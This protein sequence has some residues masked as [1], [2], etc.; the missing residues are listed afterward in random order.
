MARSTCWAPGLGALLVSALMAGCGGGGDSGSNSGGSVSGNGGASAAGAT[1]TVPTTQVALAQEPNA[2]RFT[3]N[4]ATDG[5]NWFNY[6][7]Q[8]IGLTAVERN[9]LLDT[10]ALAHSN[11]QKLNNVITHDEIQGNPGFTGVNL[12]DLD[13]AT[14]RFRAAGYRFT[15]PRY[16]FGEVISATGDTSGFN[17]AED[18]IT[19]IYHRF[20]IFEPMF[21]EV[22]G[23][24]ATVS[25]GYTYFT[26]NFAAD[27]LGPGLGRGGVITYPAANQQNVPVNFYSD[28]ESPDPVPNKNE[29]GFPISIHADITSEINLQ[30]FTL[31]ARGGAP[32]NVI[33]L[34][35]RSDVH[36]PT[37][38]AAI[39]PV[40][41]LAS[42]TTYDAQFTGTVDG[43]PVSR[44]WSFK[45]K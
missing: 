13:A 3:G 19:A 36:T 27:G 5:L 26:T 15:Q 24:S 8:Q 22:G 9:G 4:T 35:S 42:G 31:Q 10:A 1:A 45:T 39:I 41:V 12:Y 21:K 37:S 29:V 18:L 34:A 43:V 17:A 28:R 2:P 38:A 25:G 23:G 40:D 33:T 6:R 14:D 7:R 44:S 11:Y 20:V 32:V 30:S 16:A